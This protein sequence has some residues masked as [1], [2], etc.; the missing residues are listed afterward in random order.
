MY[1][2][3]AYRR[4]SL[5]LTIRDESN[6]FQ[7]LR[8][9]IDAAR[10]CIDYSRVMSSPIPQLQ[11]DGTDAALAQIHAIAGRIDAAPSDLSDAV[12]SWQRH[13]TAMGMSPK[14]V[15]AYV[16][17]VN[18]AIREQGW[19]SVSDINYA[20]VTEYL[21]RKKADGDWTGTTYNRNLTT[22]RSLSKHLLRTKLIE[23]DEISLADRSRAD[24][25]DGA[26]AATTEEAKAMIRAAW[27]REIADKR[28]T[29][30]RALIR[31][32]QFLLALRVGE[33]ARLQW[34]H[35]LLDEKVPCVHWT[36]DIN[37]NRKN[38]DVAIPSQLV[39][40]LKA[41]REK[42]RELA[43]TTPIYQ[44]RKRRGKKPQGRLVDPNNPAAFVF[45]VQTGKTTWDQDAEN[46]GVK[47]IDS[48]GRPFTPHSARKWFSTTLTLMNVNQGVIDA[49]MRHH[50]ETSSRYQD[51]PA[52]RRVAEMLPHLW[53]VEVR[54]EPVDK[55]NFLS[56]DLTGPGI[57]GQD[58]YARPVFHTVTSASVPAPPQTGLAT[59]G[60]M[61]GT[62][63]DLDSPVGAGRS[64]RFIQPVMPRVV[65]ENEHS[66]EQA[67]AIA[68]LLEAAARVLRGSR[69]KRSESA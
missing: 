56:V 25:V 57:G 17:V 60:R 21:A 2:I 47:K 23:E 9:S 46:S 67:E 8:I 59:P 43:R 29:A 18:A 40:L 64:P 26:R 28:C 24:G 69:G 55:G 10:G 6:G 32:C 68:D 38:Q 35:M 58:I 63:L 5:S 13:M 50:G 39:P 4:P 14:S 53:P 19:A 16:G 51:L 33:Y 42:M 20:Q 66:T 48:R 30:P 37:K 31:A 44:P 3:D 34:K 1:Q 41:H 49:L 11:G 22:F 15:E 36:R 45:P 52:M 61:A 12:L 62:E 27:A 65:L 7:L 54:E